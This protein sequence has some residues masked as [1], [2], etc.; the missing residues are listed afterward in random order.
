MSTSPSQRHR[1]LRRHA[2]ENA[3]TTSP[4]TAVS[5]INDTPGRAPENDRFGRSV[6][7]VGAVP[8]NDLVAPAGDRP[9]EAADLD[10]HLAVGEVAHDLVDPLR[11]EF[12]VGVVVDLT[13]DFFRVPREPHLAPRI[14]GTEQS[15]QPVVL[16]AGEAFAGHHEAPAGPVERVVFVASMPEGVVLHAATALIEC[17]VR[18]VR[19]GR[20][21]L[22]AFRWVGL[23]G[24]SRNSGGWG[25]GTWSPSN[26]GVLC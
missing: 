15:H 5:D 9:T 24:P 12:V 22:S 16:L 23:F 7:D 3:S 19:S 11:G 2:P 4:N 6:A 25:G 26:R 20:S 13:D 17:C 8:S 1:G 18:E 21:A 14:A 10:G